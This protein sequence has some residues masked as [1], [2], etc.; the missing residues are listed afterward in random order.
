MSQTYNQNEDAEMAEGDRLYDVRRD[1]E[2][3]DNYES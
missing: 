3:S 2:L 1:N